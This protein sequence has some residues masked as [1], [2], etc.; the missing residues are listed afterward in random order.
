[1][2]NMFSMSSDSASI[3]ASSASTSSGKCTLEECLAKFVAEEVLDGDNM[4]KCKKCKEQ[5]KCIK[6]LSIYKYPKILV[7]HMK[8]FRYSVV[9]REKLST[10]VSFPIHELNLTSYLSTDRIIPTEGTGE[11]RPPPPPI[12]DLTGVSNHSGSMNGGHYIA[13]VDT[14]NGR[15]GGGSGCAD[16]AP[17]WMCFNDARVTTAST[18]NISGPSA[19]LLFY[20]L[21]EGV[22]ES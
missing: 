17:K 9:S 8:R 6:K 19:Y 11:G 1:M 22:V 3:G 2:N 12:Y 14:D 10:D 15:A 16:A 13:H 4:Y 21:R 7:I 20:K 5:R 18:A